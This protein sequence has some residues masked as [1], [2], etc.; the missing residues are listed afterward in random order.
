MKNK[1]LEAMNFCLTNLIKKF[2]QKTG[3][4]YDK[5]TLREKNYK[6]LRGTEIIMILNQLDSWVL[7]Q[8]NF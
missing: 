7:K 8:I 4:Y 2:L 3:F 1:I 5:T 6:E